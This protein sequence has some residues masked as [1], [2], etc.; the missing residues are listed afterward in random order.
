M[1]KLLTTTVAAIFAVAFVLAVRAQVLNVV[2][3]N[4]VLTTQ[5][6]T[7]YTTSLVNASGPLTYTDAPNCLAIGQQLGNMT[8]AAGQKL[9]LPSYFTNQNFTLDIVIQDAGSV[10]PYSIAFSVHQ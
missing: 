8:N 3:T 9:F 5:V 2:Q 1:K 6:V 4:Q 10:V 7:N